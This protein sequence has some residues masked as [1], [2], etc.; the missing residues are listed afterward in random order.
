M[1]RFL[2][3]LLTLLPAV[4]SPP[5][6]GAEAGGRAAKLLRQTDADGNGMISRAEAK[7]APALFAAFDVIDANRDGQITP[8]ELRAWNKGRGAR[9]K[10]GSKTKSGLEAAFARADANGDGSLSRGECESSLPRVARSFDTIDANRDGNVTLAEL[11]AYAQ[12]KREARG[13][14]FVR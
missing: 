12:A 2:V 8:D 13:R 14:V 3:L 4:L 5:A 7:A 10:S 1:M 11:R 9:E 6:H